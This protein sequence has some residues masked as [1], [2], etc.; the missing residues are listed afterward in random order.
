M[1]NRFHTGVSASLFVVYTR[2]LEQELERKRRAAR[3][4]SEWVGEPKQRLEFEAVITGERV[5]ESDWGSTTLVK[6]ETDEGEALSWFS[7]AGGFFDGRDQL[8]IGDR[9]IF[10]GTVKAHKEYQGRRETQL[11]RCTFIERVKDQAA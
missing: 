10:R 1:S 8:T 6:L 3:P 5:L 9:L 4:P 7:S 11:T 2:A